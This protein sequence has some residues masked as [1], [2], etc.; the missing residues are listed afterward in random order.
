MC[1]R[2]CFLLVIC[3]LEIIEQHVSFFQRV[4]KWRSVI[5][6]SMTICSGF[7]WNSVFCFD[8]LCPGSSN[9]GQDGWCSSRPFQEKSEALIISQLV[10]HFIEHSPQLLTKLSWPSW[11]ESVLQGLWQLRGHIISRMV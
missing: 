6:F 11:Q 8:L 2:A 3:F 4:L 9:L 7:S 10:R 1:K 5:S